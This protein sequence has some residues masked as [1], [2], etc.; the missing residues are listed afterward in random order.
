MEGT[1]ITDTI[2]F[3]NT[4]SKEVIISYIRTSCGCSVADIDKNR[5]AP[6]DTAEIRVTIDTRGF[7][8]THRKDV[9]VAFADRNIGVKKFVYQFT[10][11]RPM[12][13]QPKYFYLKNIRVNPDTTITLVLRIINN[14]KKSLKIFNL[15]T[16]NK[17]VRVLPTE[18]EIKP[19][20][21]KL[22]T[23]NFTPVEKGLKI[24]YIWM[25]TDIKTM[26]KIAVPFYTQIGE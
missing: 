23:I 10:T 7:R 13:H 2:R 5:I 4:T 1:V 19:E 11:Y 8:G 9:K 14:Q 22:L 17:M 6:L 20:R 21:S 12:E 26:Q 25:E 3:I 16:N 24:I 15:H 18:M